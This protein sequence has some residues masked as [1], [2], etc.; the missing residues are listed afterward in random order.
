MVKTDLSCTLF[1]RE[2]NYRKEERHPMQLQMKQ[3]YV[4]RRSSH[5]YAEE[6]T[7]QEITSKISRN[8]LSLEDL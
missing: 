6:D 1:I 4:P 3:F 5:R 7:A 8:I 2:P